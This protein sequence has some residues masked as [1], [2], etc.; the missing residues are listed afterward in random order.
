[1]AAL[2]R[3]FVLFSQDAKME[4]TVLSN[5][6]LERQV[7]EYRMNEEISWACSAWISTINADGHNYST[8]YPKDRV[9]TQIA[10]SF[11][12]I[13]PIRAKIRKLILNGSE[14]EE[15][16]NNFKRTYLTIV[17]DEDFYDDSGMDTDS[18]EGSADDSAE[19]EE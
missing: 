14:T 5:I 1:M 8:L 15:R 9:F 11:N 12:S 18:G 2:A 19:E 16:N 6:F 7:P 10:Q 4:L 17:L 13:C 3:K